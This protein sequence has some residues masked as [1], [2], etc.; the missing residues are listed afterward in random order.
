[1]IIKRVIL[2]VVLLIV[3]I[4]CSRSIHKKRKRCNGGWYNNR[5]LSQNKKKYTHKFISLNDYDYIRYH[6]NNN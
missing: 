2:I 5:N 3:I 4:G 6:Y 1:M